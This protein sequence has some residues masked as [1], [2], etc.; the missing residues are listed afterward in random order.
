MNNQVIVYSSN[1]C[2]EC[3]YVKKFLEK[4][5]ISFEVRNVNE[6]EKYKREVEK[7]GFLGVPV[8]LVSDT[9][10]KGFTLELV[11]LIEESQSRSNQ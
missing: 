11:K 4:K 9:A 5:G 2:V 3:S 8:K 6:S 7:F 1:D 10:V